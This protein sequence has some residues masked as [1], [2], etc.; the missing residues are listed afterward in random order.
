MIRACLSAGTARTEERRLLTR[1]RKALRP[2]SE[3]IK[4]SPMADL[5]TN[6]TGI[7]SP[8]PFWLASGPP[9]N[10]YGQVA[11]AFDAGWG[12]AGWKTIREPIINVFLRYGSVALA[13]HLQIA[14]Y[15]IS[16]I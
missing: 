4:G 13:P 1:Q 5:K 3:S 8:N 14:V 6:F 10:T 9:T 16:V 12:G 2:P 11:K 15:N 7:E